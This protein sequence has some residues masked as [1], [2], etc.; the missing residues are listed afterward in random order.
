[1]AKVVVGMSGGVD[2]SVAAYLLK[3]Q[4]Y[5]VIGL[6]MRNWEE[7]DP[8]GICTA[9][10]DFSDVRRVS[11][12]LSIPYYTI[13]FSKDYMDKVFKKFVSDYQKGLTPNPDVLCNREIKFSS[14]ADYARTIGADYIATGHY[15]D[16]DHNGDVHILKTAADKN[17]DQTYF[18]SMV[19]G[20][21]LRDVL[22]PLGKI[23]KPEVRNIAAKLGL[24]TAEKKDSTGICF[25]GERNFR[26]FLSGYIPM[27]EGVTID[28]TNG[29]QVGKHRGVF[30]YT[31]GQRRGLGIGGLS[32]GNGESWYVVDKD[33]KNNILYVCQGLN[34]KLFC[35]SLKT[36]GFN[37]ISVRPETNTFDCYCRIRHR[38]PLEK[39]RGTLDENGNLTLV[40]DKP[41]KGVARGQYAVIYDYPAAEICYGGGEIDKTVSV[42]D[43]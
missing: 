30:Y 6:F 19:Q 31:V 21:Q 41:I 25:I 5:D 9:D 35:K 17:K 40:F 39:A 34:D 23:T 28:I 8:S 13:N 33:V 32:D 43:E 11:E 2:S 12:I 22:F 14:F 37:F 24:S 7:D 26:K 29:R 27:K 16:I 15:C 10:E 3:Q 38:Q 36:D 4:G 20:E 42:A 18:L 1:M